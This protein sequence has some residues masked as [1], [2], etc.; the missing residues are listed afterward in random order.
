MSDLT[1]NGGMDRLFHGKTKTDHLLW[2]C[3]V[4]RRERKKEEEDKKKKSKKKKKPE[5][6]PEIS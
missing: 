4:V 5:G 3:L 1:L 2:Y 6:Q